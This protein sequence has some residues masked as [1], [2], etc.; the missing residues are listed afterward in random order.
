M[1]NLLKKWYGD[2]TKEELIKYVSLG[3]IFSLLIGIYWTLRPLKDSIFGSMVVGFGK[4]GSGR[5]VFLAWAK[6]VSMLV[7]FP[8]VGIY[9]KMVDKFKDNKYKF[10]YL[11][12]T[13]YGVT[14]L[15]WAAFFA[16]P[17]GLQ[18]AVPSYYRIAGWLWYVFVES[19]GS[20]II[21]LFWAFVT[22]IS[23]SESA[24]KGFSL[25]VMIGQ[26]GGILMPEYLTKIPEKLGTTVYPLVGICGALVLLVVVLLKMFVANTPKDQLSGYKAKKEDKH[27]DEPGFLEGLKLML[28]NNYLL[29]IF[30]VLSFFELITTIIDFNFK[31][32][33]FEQFANA[34]AATQYLGWYGS[35]VNLV[36]FIFLAL[37]VN[38]ISRWLGI[39]TALALV[40]LCLGVSVWM[41]KL[42]PIVDVLAYLMI[43]SK[44]INYALNG[45][46]LK[47]LYVPTS[48]DAKYKSQAWI[49]T[50]GSRGAK[51]GA[52]FLNMKKA[53]FGSLYMSVCVYFS[54]G[55][56]AAWFLIALYLGNTYV[57]ATSEDKLVC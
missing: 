34:N 31:S 25:I 13:F 30:A 10:L 23:T 8:V 9:G 21:A 1:L 51:A 54:L 17:W 28:S 16:S 15:F 27:E 50:F 38:N 24:K 52:S 45:P 47:Q 53:M 12:A 42:Y 26:L 44:A 37:G 43:A 20:L 39:R 19:F 18:D 55:L 32:L 35:R 33:V 46:A 56:V 11:L 22:D 14:M 7:L 3:V 6:V 49:E 57:K 29:G 36:A 4:A 40:P 5:E 2:F 48:D 41:F